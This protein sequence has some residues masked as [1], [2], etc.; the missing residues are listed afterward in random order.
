M[1]IRQKLVALL[2]LI[3][4]VPTVIVSIVSFITISG[5]LNHGTQTQL[6]AIATK[7]QQAISSLLQTKQQDLIQLAEAY[8]F[9]LALQQY[10]STG[11][12]TSQSTV[13]TVMDSK[14]SAVSGMSQIQVAD[15]KGTVI[16]STDPTQAGTQLPRQPAPGAAYQGPDIAIVEDPTTGLRQLEITSAL[17]IN[18]LYPAVLRAD[19]SVSDLEAQLSDYT[20]LG[21]TGETVIT[22]PDT[23][24]QSASLFPLRFNQADSGIAPYTIGPTGSATSYLNQPVM[25]A[26]RP[27]GF[28]NWTI[29]TM[30]ETQEALAPIADLRNSLITIAAISCVIITLL[31]LYLA[32]LFTAPILALANAASR[33]GDGDFAVAINVSSRDEL[34]ALAG[35]I[36]NMRDSLRKFVASIQSHD[37]QLSIVL[38][39]TTDSIL[40]VNADGIIITTNQSAVDL[41]GIP[42]VQIIGKPM[43]DVFHLTTQLEPFI[44]DYTGS[45][46]STHD[47][48]EFDNA[49]HAKHYLK[50]IV[51]H[52]AASADSPR[53]SIITIRDETTSREL[54]SMKLDFV[55]MAAHELRTPLAAMR[56]YIEL[57]NYKLGRASPEVKNYLN[58]SLKSSAELS[59]LINNLL[60]VSRIERGTLTLNMT[61]TDFA[62]SVAHA[63]KDVNFQA[64]DRKIVLHA[65]VPTTG[66][67]VAA[68]EIAIREVVTNLLTNAIKYTRSGGRVDAALA[69]TEDAYLFTVRD[70]G[71]GIPAAAL[72][73]L[74]TKFFR[75]HGGLASGSS[76]TGLGLFIAKSIIDRHGGTIAVESEEGKGSTFTVSI[77]KLDDDK[78][79]QIEAGAQAEATTVRRHR[80]WVT[81]NTSR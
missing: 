47:N 67:F 53:Q 69:Q 57:I 13:E 65:A 21:V 74:F 14:L 34:G 81:K 29:A 76:G 46:S 9:Q 58:Q 79:A 68:D 63:I 18:D 41:A 64:V 49:T 3:G 6:A 56:G 71:I 39:S 19:Y 37:N 26:S 31:A 45:G 36:I 24:G 75:V 11:S 54:E 51:T 35:S 28:S 16:A 80:G 5:Q 22:Q 72:P 1:N 48:I 2:L 59:S 61:K 12:A 38:N 66:Y 55:S 32:R 50:L 4:L 15:E 77:P 33:I 23:A 17:E 10:L 60:D 25:V 42:L 70:T 44:V 8:D 7:Q 52:L 78:L 30:I 73:H 62:A 27:L 43:H 40:A 20:G